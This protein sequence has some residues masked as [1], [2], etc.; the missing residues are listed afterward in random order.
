[1]GIG[2]KTWVKYFMSLTSIFGDS[3]HMKLIHI[4]VNV[5]AMFSTQAHSSWAQSQN[6]LREKKVLC[7]GCLPLLSFYNFYI[8][9]S[10]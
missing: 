7:D 1:M 5:N 2:W 10:E 4:K 6:I 9:Q 3:K 8:A